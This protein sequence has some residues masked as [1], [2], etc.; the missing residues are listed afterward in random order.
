VLDLRGVLGLTPREEARDLKLI[1]LLTPH[2]STASARVKSGRALS[3]SGGLISGGSLCSGGASVGPK[4]PVVG[5]CSDGGPRASRRAGRRRGSQAM[6]CGRPSSHGESRPISRRQ[7]R[8]SGSKTRNNSQRTLPPLG[9]Q[10]LQIHFYVLQRPCPSSLSTQ[11]S[12]I[13][14]GPS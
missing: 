7:Y 9:K 4:V 5:A 3:G 6:G 13:F 8:P 10:P 2:R 12:P 1:P 11:H 14:L